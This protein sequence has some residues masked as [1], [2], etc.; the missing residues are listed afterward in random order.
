MLLGGHGVISVTA[1]VAP[2]LMHEMC[3][4]ALA[5]DVT[6]ARELNHRAAAAA[7]ATCSSRPTR[8]RSS[9]RWPQMGLIERRHAPAADA[10]R[11]SSCHE[12]V[13]EALREA[14]I[15]LPTCDVVE[16][17]RLK[18][19]ACAFACR[20]ALSLARLQ[21]RRSSCSRPRR[22]TTRA[23]GQAA[24]AR[25]AARPDHAGARQPLRGARRP[26]RSATLSGYQAERAASGAAGVAR[27]ACCR[28][29]DDVRIE[30]AGTQRWLVVQGHAR[31][32]LAAGASDFWQETGFLVTIEH[33]RSRRDGDRLGREPRQDPAGHHPRHARQAARLRSTRPPSA[34]SSAPASSAAP[35]GNAPRS[36]SATAA[37]R[38]STPR[39]TQD[40]DRLAAAR[41]RPELEA[42][43]PAPPDGAA[44]ASQEEQRQAAGRARAG[45]AGARA[46]SLQEPATA[47]STLAGE[48][49]VRPRLAPRRPRARPRRLHRRGPR[50]PEG[51]VLRALRR[52][53]DRRQAAQEPEG[54]A[55]RKL[56]FWRQSDSKVKAEQYRIQVQ[57]VEASAQVNVLNKDGAQEN[58]ETA[59]RSS[60]CSTSSSSD[61]A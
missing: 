9:G 36:T 16:R 30:R 21:H 28:R 38:R 24:A 43:M 1:N 29:V 35:S 5:G 51:P 60:R 57:D 52:S 34:T 26:Q 11:R 12:P 18:H 7:P 33:A 32:A 46:R 58:S 6:K 48:R 61:V 10:A 27:P 44:A 59:R 41:R 8:S 53:R 25:S 39:A 2:R 37:W 49:A 15:A 47:P 13:R 55:R 4:A 56:K 19:H 45:R 14:G 31:A 50:P 42:E 40:A 23:A 17:P 54:L 22:S 20:R 3:A